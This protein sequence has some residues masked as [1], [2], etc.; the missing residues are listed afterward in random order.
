LAE[1]RQR[2]AA[3]PP[4]DLVW[5]HQHPDAAPPWG[6]RIALTITSLDDYYWTADGRNLL[7]VLDDAIGRSVEFNRDVVVR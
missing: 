1:I 6:G 2:L 4:T 5:D 7:D 3:L